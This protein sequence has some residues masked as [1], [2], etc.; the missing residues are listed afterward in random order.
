MKRFSLVF[1]VVVLGCVG[2]QAAGNAHHVTAVLVPVEGSGVTGVVNLTA[3]P[4]GGTQVSVVAK[5]L[6]PG[7]AYLSLYYDN[8]VCDL[9][10]YSE[11]DIIGHYI[12]RPGGVASTMS[13]AADDL[14]EINSVSVR[15]ADFNL[16]ACA[17]VHDVS[18]SSSQ[19]APTP[20][21][22]IG[23]TLSSS[24]R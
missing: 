7:A 14:D 21:T 1:I 22:P 12:G 11:D 3:L 9:E 23:R 15:D 24:N 16:L 20:R 6:M 4:Q 17:Q 2:A 13:K 10:P 19:L 18:E 5:G 8:D